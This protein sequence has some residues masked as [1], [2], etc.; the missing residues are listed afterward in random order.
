[1][2]QEFARK[3][4]LRNTKYPVQLELR[5]TEINNITGCIYIYIYHNKIT[6]YFSERKQSKDG[7]WNYKG[8]IGFHVNKL[9]TPCITVRMFT[10][11]LPIQLIYVFEN[12]STSFPLRWL[13]SADAHF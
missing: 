1:M 3:A 6:V 8:F 9:A 13:L 12:I 4:K 7:I 10:L 2:L 5:R 11:Y